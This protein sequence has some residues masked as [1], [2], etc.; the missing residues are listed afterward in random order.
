[1]LLEEAAMTKITPDGQTIPLPSVEAF[2]GANEIRAIQHR[3][4]VQRD[5]I[6]DLPP[7]AY[8]ACSVQFF[9]RTRKASL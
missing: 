6:N 8:Q 2:R 1:M 9:T 4:T 5:W 3:E 7:G